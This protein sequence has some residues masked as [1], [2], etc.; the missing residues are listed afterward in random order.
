[1][2][3]RVATSL[4]IFGLLAW[5]ALA[6]QPGHAKAAQGS[7]IGC[8]TPGLLRFEQDALLGQTVVGEVVPDNSISTDEPWWTA[9]P[10]HLKYR[11]SDYPHPN[12]SDMGPAIYLFPLRGSYQ[13]LYPPA[14][15]DFWLA[16]VNDLRATLSARPAWKPPTWQAGES[17]TTPPLLPTINAANVY[18]ARQKYV[19]LPDGVGVSYISYM[20]QDVSPPSPDGTFYMFQGVL[21]DKVNGGHY[22]VSAVFP[23]F[24]SAPPAFTPIGEDS[25]TAEA[26]FIANALGN[27]ADA[28]FN[29]DLTRLDKLV[30]S[31]V[32]T[33]LPA[34]TPNMPATGGNALDTI[35]A[36]MLAAIFTLLAGAA[37]R[38]YGRATSTLKRTRHW[39][40]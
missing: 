22:Y 24:L 9:R 36:A 38:L 37:L 1:M 32:L 3:L 30:S 23:V 13:S 17:L 31:I 28:D 29:V 10:C 15:T 5:L 11:F 2:K 35:R 25:A 27:A 8:P 34:N 33:P 7:D 6:L 18:I 40:L 19:T 16:E 12:A 14:S 26:K 4:S 20:T 39:R 21:D